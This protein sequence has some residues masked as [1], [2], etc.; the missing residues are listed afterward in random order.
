MISIYSKKAKKSFILLNNDIILHYVNIFFIMNEVVFG[1]FKTSVVGINTF[2][3]HHPSLGGKKPS[4]STKR[5]LPPTKINF[6]FVLED[7]KGKENG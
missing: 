6:V 5:P 2:L 3:K 7:L 4:N 1:S